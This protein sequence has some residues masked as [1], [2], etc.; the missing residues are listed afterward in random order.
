MQKRREPINCSTRVVNL[1]AFDLDPTGEDADLVNR[2]YSKAAEHGG[3][4]RDTAGQVR[5]KQKL[6]KDRY[7]GYLAEDQLVKHLQAQLGQDFHV[8]SREFV[9]Y[10]DHVDIEIEVDGRVVTTVE[11]RSSFL[12]IQRPFIVCR[13]HGVIG[14]YRTQQKPIENPK[15]FYLYAFINEAVEQ[16]NV[17]RKHTLF[18]PAGAPY[19]MLLEKGEWR[20]LRR[21]GAEYL[22]LVPMANAMDSIE[23]V[24]AIRRHASGIQV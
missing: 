20:D 6:L 13:A 4:T 14:P 17:E 10:S 9:T 15:D 22:V 2:L 23:V 24:E 19:S 16:F 5:D 7:I 8:C 3:D 1:V 12:Y 21:Q 11:V 18:F